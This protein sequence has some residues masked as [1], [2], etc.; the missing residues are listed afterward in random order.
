M[1]TCKSP[2]K[3]MRVAHLLASQSLP[4]HTCKSSRKDFTLPQLFACLTVKEMLKRSY[5]GAEALLRDCEHWCK[6]IGLRRVPDHNTL[7]RAATFLLKACRVSK[8][9]DRVAEWAAVGRI[10]GLSRKPLAVDS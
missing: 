7:Q 9:L 5:R 10:L 6:D 3:V 2:R 4:K 1:L 8:L